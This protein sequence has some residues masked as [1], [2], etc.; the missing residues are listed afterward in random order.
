M[1]V[2][3][4]QSYAT[5]TFNLTTG[6]VN[7]T[8]LVGKPNDSG[9]GIYI[10]L[11]NN[12]G[13]IVNPTVETMILYATR[14][15]GTKVYFIGENELDRIRIDFNSSIYEVVGN[16]N[17]EIQLIDS[18]G[19]KKTS[20]TFTINASEQVFDAS[21]VKSTDD[22]RVLKEALEDVITVQTDLQNI[23]PEQINHVTTSEEGRVVAEEGR[24]VAEN[25]R[26]IAESGRQEA[27]DAKA[28]TTYVD[29]QIDTIDS[30]IIVGT[31]E[32]PSSPLPRV[33]DRLGSLSEQDITSQLAEI[34]QDK[35]E[36]TDVGLLS[37]LLT[38]AKTSIVNAINE[39]FN[40]K[41]DKTQ[42][43]WITPT[44]INGAIQD[45]TH[46][47]QYY[48]DQFGRVYFRGRASNVPNDK[49]LFT[50]PTGYRPPV[51]ESYN[52]IITPRSTMNMSL[53]RIIINGGWGIGVV[54]VITTAP[55][56]V[57]FDGFNYKV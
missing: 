50:M 21:Y 3:F 44:L 23:T 34:E 43:A 16:V 41:A 31:D 56:I 13:A 39:L 18:N 29:S 24:V 40:K 1:A 51:S 38:T 11:I 27:L 2:D 4:S 53:A 57:H 47:V 6:A 46:P 35:A 12:V 14:P 52:S 7:I 20:N 48:K 45:P 26:V 55:D 17:A 36:K 32:I 8:Y 54:Y 30:K 10:N 5:G 42:E 15:D 28:D 25:L 9:A 49:A 22:F 19:L 33:A 37:G